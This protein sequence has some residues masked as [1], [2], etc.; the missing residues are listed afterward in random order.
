[1]AGSPRVAL[2]TMAQDV[3]ADDDLPSMIEALRARGVDARAVA[4][5]APGEDWAA[6][7]QVVIRSTWDYAER[8]EEF[9]AWADDVARVTVLRNP[10]EVVRWNS[11][12]RYLRWLSDR[13]VS[14]LPTTF[15]EPGA[16]A[17]LPDEPDFVLK[18]VVSAGAQDTARY[19]LDQRAAAERHLAMLH[20]A[21]K[22]AMVQPYLPQ[23]AQ[24]ERAL[25]FLDGRFS[26]AIRKGPVLVETGVIDNARMPHPDLARHEP[27]RAE[28]ELAARALA[29][30]PVAAADLLYARVDMALDGRGEPVLMELEL[31]E[32]NL[33]LGWAPTGVSH[34]A[35]AVQVQLARSPSDLRRIDRA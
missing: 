5:D 13:G 16:G 26:H 15:I 10:A 30:A 7:D 14:V 21:G 24:G 23:I 28:L 35:D 3:D 17:I 1:M 4:W 11:D 12:K 8:I 18:P 33:F 9:L 29:A 20:A 27:T 25:V 19:T 22:P 6:F 2:A 34:F 31:I 32:P